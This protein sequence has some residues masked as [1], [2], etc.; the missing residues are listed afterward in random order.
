[1]A[2]ASITAMCFEIGFGIFIGPIYD[3]VGRRI[4]IILSS[5][6]C[7]ISLGLIPLFTDFFASQS[8]K[9]ARSKANFVH[10]SPTI[11][12]CEELHSQI[13]RR[14]NFG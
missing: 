4:P 1:M 10:R 6:I 2:T 13:G 9:I 11:L 14:Y 8:Y 5:V 12:T 3:S 7:A